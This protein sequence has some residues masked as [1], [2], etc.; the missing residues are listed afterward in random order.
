MGLVPLERLDLRKCDSVGDIVKAMSKCSFGARMLGEVC[1]KVFD[2][3]QRGK[4]IRIVYDGEK[5]LDI[6]DR[7]KNNRWIEEVI[8]SDQVENLSGWHTHKT[9]VV[10]RYSEAADK[11]INK[12]GD[13]VFIN[14]EELCRPGQIKDGYFPDVVFAEPTFVIPILY[15]ALDNWLEDRRHSIEALFTELEKDQF[16]HTVVSGGLTLEKMVKDPDCSVFLTLSGAM[17]IAKMGLVICDMVD[18]DMIQLISSTGALMAHGLIESVGLQ[19]FKHNPAHDDQFLAQQKLN[20]VTD[21]LEPEKNFTHIEKIVNEI[22][23]SFESGEIIGPSVFHR[24]VGEYLAREFTTERGVLKSAFEKNVPVLCPAFVDS[25]IGNDLFA[26]N[27]RRMQIGQKRLIVDPELDSEVLIR[28]MIQTSKVGIFSVGGGVPRN[29]TQNVAP[30]IEITNERLSYNW[31]EK[32][33]LY[34]CRIAPDAMHYGH[35]SGCTYS[36]NASW[37]K[38]DTK[39]GTFAEIRGDATQIWPFLVKYVMDS[40][41]F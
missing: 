40:K 22:L 23:W 13:A 2:W 29:N 20:R 41:N 34:G 11:H 3:V 9:I 28:M 7:M 19:H 35:L 38:M 14:K 27:Q 32:M 6:F 1:L 12:L 24:R 16:G 26:H 8:H 30:L 39:L 37:R 5:L 36:E 4:H 21:T 25:E 15:C 17:T 31:P 33:Y 18:L 10:G